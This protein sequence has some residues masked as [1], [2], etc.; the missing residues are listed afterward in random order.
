[1]RGQ[2][3]RKCMFFIFVIWNVVM[4]N[5]CKVRVGVRPG[6]IDGVSSP[7]DCIRDSSTLW[8]EEMLPEPAKLMTRRSY[9][10]EINAGRTRIHSWYVVEKAK[11]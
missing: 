7:M 1:M 4:V 2:Y 8:L 6:G 10:L 9:L 5:I 3:I 11:A